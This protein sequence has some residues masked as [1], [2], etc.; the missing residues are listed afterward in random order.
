MQSL[1]KQIQ[2]VYQLQSPVPETYE[3]AV[4][5]FH[6]LLEKY[7]LFLFIDSLDQLSDRDLARSKI[8]FLR[9]VR[10]HVHTRIVVSSLPDD[11]NDGN[12]IP[13]KSSYFLG[14]E[15]RLL[16][17]EVPRV[18]VETFDAEDICVPMQSISISGGGG[19][20]GSVSDLITSGNEDV[21]TDVY[22]SAQINRNHNSEIQQMLSELLRRSGRQLTQQQWAR[23][24]PRAQVEPTALY[25]RLAVNRISCWASADN[26]CDLAP[27]VRGL[28]NQIVDDL[29][30]EFGAN[31]TRASLGYITFS[32]D[33]I[34]DNEMIDLLSLNDEVLGHKGKEGTVFQ[35]TEPSRRRLPAHVWMRVRR[36]LDGLVMER[37]GNR[38][39]WYHRQLWE[40][41]AL[42]FSDSERMSYQRIMGLYFANRI[43]AADRAERV[44]Q[45]QPLLLVGTSVWDESSKINTRRCLEAAHHLLAAK[46]YMAAAEEL[47]SIDAVYASVLAN[48][49]VDLVNRFGMLVDGLQRNHQLEVNHPLDRATTTADHFLRWVRGN[50][51]EIMSS[52]LK[53]CISSG[54]LKFQLLFA[55]VSDL[56]IVYMTCRIYI[57]SPIAIR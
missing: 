11:A 5:Y 20:A 27:G 13:G 57:S 9:N 29:E 22:Y 31:L 16:E 8:S 24:L 51:T 36:A 26:A 23:V 18:V 21:N 25:V 44:I 54:T 47:C 50:L 7:P 38:L 28:I 6:G 45:E 19:G 1:C 49:G 2:A 30:I 43:S 41:V 33:G 39:T 55:I 4:A 46:E 35:Y 32:L 52:P 40:T 3:E 53:G 34:D 10:P 56:L 37:D 14:C 15:T 17:S 42:R 12:A 48:V